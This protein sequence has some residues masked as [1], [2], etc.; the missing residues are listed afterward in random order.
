MPSL[1]VMGGIGTRVRQAVS[2][3]SAI[4][5]MVEEGEIMLCVRIAYRISRIA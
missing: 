5:S 2:S 4:V 3:R 1:S